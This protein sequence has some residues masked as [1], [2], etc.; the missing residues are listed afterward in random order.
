MNIFYSNLSEAEYFYSV[1]KAIICFSQRNLF[2]S[3]QLTI[4]FFVLFLFFLFC[5]FGQWYMYGGK[6][7]HEPPC[8]S[9]IVFSYRSISLIMEAWIYIEDP[10]S[11]E[12]TV[13]SHQ[14]QPL[15]ISVSCI[16]LSLVL[17]DTV[18]AHKILK[19][20]WNFYLFGLNLIKCVA[21]GS[22]IAYILRVK[23]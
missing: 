6:K 9:L 11:I 14:P 20:N 3:V 16:I 18:M 22:G 7:H 19:T 12:F 5:F 21:V 23:F 15:L 17:Y 10:I 1:K 8:G 4:F 2:I 13:R